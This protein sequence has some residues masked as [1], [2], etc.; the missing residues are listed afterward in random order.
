MSDQLAPLPLG[1][2]LLNKAGHGLNS[3]GLRP[4]NLSL[5]NLLATAKKEASLDDFGDDS[6]KPPLQRLLKSLEIEAQLNLMGRMIARNNLLGLLK[7]RLQII[8]TFKRHPEIREEKIERPIIVVGPPRTG[9]TVFHDLLAMDSSNRVPLS[10]ET[11]MPCPP[12]ETATYKTDPRIAKVQQELDQV[13]KLVP[14]FKKMHPMGAERAQECVAMVAH[15]FTS[16]IF[17]VQ[18]R[19]PSYEEWMNTADVSDMFK[20]HQEFLQML[21]WKAPA[22]RWALKS[23]QHLWHMKPLLEQ[24]P[25]A[26]LVQ[27]HRDPARVLVSIASLIAALR[28]LGS[29]Q[30]NL[31]DIARH[32]AG[33]LAIGYEHTMHVRDS[34][35][36]PASQVF[37]IQ[38]SDFVQ[39]Q[40]GCV[41]RAYKHFDLDLPDGSTTAMQTFIDNNPADKH[42]KHMYQFKDTGLDLD[43]IRELYKPYS[44]YF[45]IPLENV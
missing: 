35:L 25:D 39:D 20:F 37:D 6:F 12:P 4:I 24:Y 44:N 27:T 43:E 9:T 42:G 23:P 3:L 45:S 7:N 41:R 31:N 14:D 36:L 19:V 22:Q 1:V 18:Y 11:A 34:G 30:V 15:Q 16:M 10:W 32:Y 40:V 17:D 2:R 13:D 8:D 29:D 28:R 5:E 26:L 21:Q 38:F 33:W